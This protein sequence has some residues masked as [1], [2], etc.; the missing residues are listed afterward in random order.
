MNLRTTI[1]LAILVAVGAIGWIFSK[2]IGE[3]LGIA[4]PTT[5]AENTASVEDLEKHLTRDKIRRIVVQGSGEPVI[6]EKGQGGAWALPGKW[7]TRPGETDE[8]VDLLTNLHT[9]F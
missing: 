8:L 1:L 9:R 5:N 2:E 6:L 3:K 7:P 4:A